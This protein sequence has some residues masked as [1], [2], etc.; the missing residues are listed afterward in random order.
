LCR[1]DKDTNYFSILDMQKLPY[2][3]VQNAVHCPL[4]LGVN[5]CKMIKYGL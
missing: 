4:T 5:K 3:D 1:E 2:H